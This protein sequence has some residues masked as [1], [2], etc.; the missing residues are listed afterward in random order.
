MSKNNSLAPV[1][2]NEDEKE[3]NLLCGRKDR[4]GEEGDGVGGR[5]GL[6]SKARAVTVPAASTIKNKKGQEIEPD[7]RSE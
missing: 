6:G 2:G 4:E 1:R 5:L 3:E 7:A